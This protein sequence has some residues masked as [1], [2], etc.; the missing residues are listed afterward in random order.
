MGIGQMSRRIRR[1]AGVGIAKY[2]SRTVS[3]YLIVEH[4]QV[5]VIDVEARQVIAGVL[6]VEYILVHN[7]GRAA[8]LGRVAAAEQANPGASESDVTEIRASTGASE[9]DVAQSRDQGVPR[10]VRE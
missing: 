6:G 3:T 1:F 10:G 4:H 2:S 7:K 9:S 8:R 5:A